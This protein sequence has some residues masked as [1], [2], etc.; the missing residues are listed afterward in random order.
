MT[1]WISAALVLLGATLMLIGS[2]GVVRMP[3]TITRLHAATKA[4]A[5]GLSFVMLAVTIELS[6]ASGLQAAL[7]VAF[8][9][10]TAPVAAHTIARAA[11]YTGV[12]LWEGT[13]RDDLRESGDVERILAQDRSAAREEDW[14]QEE[15]EAEREAEEEAERD[16][17]P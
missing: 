11:Y 17:S 8:V 3:D 5:V 16:R 15:A 7:V 14:E 1:G 12:E 13:L 10:L 9:L 4:G 2:I 6:G